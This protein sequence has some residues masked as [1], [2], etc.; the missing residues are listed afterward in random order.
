L[1]LIN[2]LPGPNT[3]HAVTRAGPIERHHE[4]RRSGSESASGSDT[5]CLPVKANFNQYGTKP[6]TTKEVKSIAE[7]GLEPATSASRIQPQ[8]LFPFAFFL[9]KRQASL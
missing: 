3:T 4:G 2:K 8:L 1:E 9:L 6:I 7:T 5:K